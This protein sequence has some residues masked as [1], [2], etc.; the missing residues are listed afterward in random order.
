VQSAVASNTSAKAFKN[1]TVIATVQSLPDPGDQ[2]QVIVPEQRY[3]NNLLPTKGQAM[4]RKFLLESLEPFTLNVQDANN[5]LLTVY[6]TA[7][8][9]YLGSPWL[10][11][12]TGP[13]L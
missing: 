6:L 1:T 10:W 3:P 9:D 4:Q 8:S 11:N 5:G 7:Y 13:G 2:I 12:S